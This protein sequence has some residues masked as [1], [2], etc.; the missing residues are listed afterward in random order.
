MSLSIFISADKPEP[1]P[2]SNP[3]HP[4]AKAKGNVPLKIH[5]MA[6]ETRSFQNTIWK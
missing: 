5:I 1:K 3:P 6:F 4:T 2:P